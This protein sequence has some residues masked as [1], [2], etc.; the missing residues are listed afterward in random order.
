LQTAHNGLASTFNQIVA[1]DLQWWFPDSGHETGR[2]DRDAPD[3]IKRF[4][5]D[6]DLETGSNFQSL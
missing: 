4:G 5:E 2:G 1:P 6:C 3:V